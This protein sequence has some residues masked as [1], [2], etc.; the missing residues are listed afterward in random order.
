[1]VVDVT[2]IIFNALAVCF[3]VSIRFRY[4]RIEYCLPDICIVFHVRNMISSV[5]YENSKV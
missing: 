4:Y 2:L 5:H 3:S 1:M